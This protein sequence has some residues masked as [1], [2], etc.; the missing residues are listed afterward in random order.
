MVTPGR[1]DHKPFVIL[2]LGLL[3]W[4][5]LP[6]FVRGFV[7]DTF[8]EFQSPLIITQ[9]R[10]EDLRKFWELRAGRSD[11]ELIEAGRDLARVNAALQLQVQQYQSLVNE[12]KRLEQLLDIPSRPQFRTIIARVARRDLN[13]WWQ[14]ITLRKGS[15]DG[16]RKGC[17]VVIGSGVVGRVKDVHLDTCTVELV[18]SPEFRISANIDGDT[19][20][21]IFQGVYNEP[22]APPKAM[23]TNIPVNYNL[24][25][26]GEAPIYVFTSGLGGVFMGGMYLGTVEEPPRNLSGDAPEERLKKTS[27]GLFLEGS[28]KLFPE[29]DRLQEAAILVPLRNDIPFGSLE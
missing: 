19:R 22:F 10:M 14:E 11:T 23:I 4:W 18:S 16:I 6:G 20:P 25:A 2:A 5:A 7:K 28:V 29:L 13:T 3:A 9:S 12:N 15:V 24:A 21:V 1:I 26:A 8:Y 17:P 27:D